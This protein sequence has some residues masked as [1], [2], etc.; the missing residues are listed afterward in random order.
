[1]LIIVEPG[2]KSKKGKAA[3]DA[4]GIKIFNIPKR[5]PDLNVLDYSIWKEVNSRMR[6]Q[7]ATWNAKKRETRKEYLERLKKTAVSLSVPL[8]RVMIVLIVIVIAHNV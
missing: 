2:F 4:V 5:S 3:K 7:E 6:A 8:L 1:M